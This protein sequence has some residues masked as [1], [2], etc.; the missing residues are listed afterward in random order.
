LEECEVKPF[1]FDFVDALDVQAE[2]ESK[3]YWIRNGMSKYGIAQFIQKYRVKVFQNLSFRQFPF[4]CH[5]L[6]LTIIPKVE[7][8][9]E[10][11]FYPYDGEMCDPDWYKRAWKGF[12]L[13]EWN[14]TD[15]TTMTW[16]NNVSYHGEAAKPSMIFST[17]VARKV[18]YYVWNVMWL[19]YFLN[20]ITWCVFIVPSDSLSDRL[21]V[22]ITIFLSELAFNLIIAGVLP[23][24]PY[25]TH[26]SIFFL[27]NYL[28][29]ALQSLEHVFVYLLATHNYGD[30]AKK[31]DYSFALGFGIMNT[32][33][34]LTAYFLSRR[35]HLQHKTIDKDKD[36]EA[37][38][39]HR[40]LSLHQSA[41]G[42]KET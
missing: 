38:K 17:V 29:I 24:V 35:F 41:D 42:L 10:L 34:V 32:L 15:S 21:S 4:D 1:M 30:V 2:S 33:L 11:E 18:H 9:S 40:S 36:L 25:N 16:Q 19:V 22:T 27:I 26:F 37:A 13:D 7:V 5:S 39:N 20:I 14:F 3:F 12:S 8:G 28:S 31:I 23:R 6:S